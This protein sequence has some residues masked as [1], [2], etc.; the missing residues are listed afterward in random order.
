MEKFEETVF[1]P[2]CLTSNL[3]IRHLPHS[4]G[5]VIVNFYLF[6]FIFFILKTFKL[7]SFLD[8][9][10]KYYILWNGLCFLSLLLLL[11][12]WNYEIAF[13]IFS[14]TFVFLF[15]KSYYL[16][17]NMHAVILFSYFFSIFLLFVYWFQFLEYF[18][19]CIFPCSNF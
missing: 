17:V 8:L 5:S 18:F 13:I 10:T 6:V 16:N 11:D 15:G 4:R 14:L 3:V 7:I 2:F 12:N 1:F 9:K 19:K